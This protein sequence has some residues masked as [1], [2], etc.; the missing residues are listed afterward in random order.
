MPEGSDRMVEALRTGLAGDAARSER[1]DVLRLR[2][3]RTLGYVELDLLVLVEGLVPLRLDRRVVDEDV[4]AAVLLGDEAEALL[5]VEPLDG[6]LSHAL[7]LL[8]LKALR[9]PLQR[10][11]QGAG[12][13]PSRLASLV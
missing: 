4:V 13:T 5:G 8:L 10:P 7:V 6:A 11:L 1:A 2:A 9:P 12:D 3:L